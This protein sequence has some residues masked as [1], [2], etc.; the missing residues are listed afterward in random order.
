MGTK[1]LSIAVVLLSCGTLLSQPKPGKGGTA[2]LRALSASFEALAQR[3]GPAVVQI[4]T[5]EYSVVEEGGVREERGSGSGAILD[6]SGYIVTNAHVVRGARSVQVLLAAPAAEQSRWKSI[7]KPRGK[8]APGR[9]VGIDNETDLAVLKIEERDLPALELADSDYLR[10]GQL[11]LAFGSPLGLDNS[12]SLGVVSSVARQLRQ[13]DPMIYLQTDAT[14][15]PGNSGGPLIDAEGRVVGINTFILSQSGGSEGIGFA[16]PSNIVRTVFDQIRKTGRVRRGQIGVSAQT[17]TPTMAVGLRLPQSWGVILGDVLPGEA[18]ELA[19]LKVGDIIISMNDKPMENA[20]QFEVNLYQQVIGDL[21]RL[22]VQRGAETFTRTVTISE[23]A[24]DPYRFAALA[25][26]EA[27]P[28]PRLGVLALDLKGSVEPLI[29]PL[30]KPAGVLV[31]ARLADAAENNELRPGDLIN[32]V[33]GVAVSNLA[34]LNS[35][36]QALRAG[37]A[38]VVQVQR[39]GQLMFLAFSLP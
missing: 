38:V 25:S 20:R 16:A 33:N 15:N 26:Q 1:T 11:V 12:V 10:Q 28:V 4:H 32:T 23:K 9:V 14:I 36:L 21:I 27:N 34:A 37:D 8:M 17:I 2:D 24:T 19:G 5:S 6:P 22:E 18:A 13:D 29:P 39:L 35:A 30:R 3:V 7:L 31:A